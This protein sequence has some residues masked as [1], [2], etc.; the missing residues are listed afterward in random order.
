MATVID[1]LIVTLG[2]D[3]AGFKKGQKEATD[4]QKRFV[5]EQEENAKK[6]AQQAKSMVEGY[7]QVRNELLGLFAAAVG[8][9]GFKDWI[10]NTV[11]G[12]AQLGYLSKNL[13]MS[14]R[15]LDAWG[16]A[17]G[18]VGGTAEGFQNSLQT[19]ASSIESFKLGEDSPAVA[20]LRSIGVNI[21]DSTGKMR[22]FK[23]MLLDVSDALQRYGAQ[24]QIR[25]GQMLGIDAP[26]LNLLRKGRQ[27]VEGLFDQMYRSSRVT[28]E[29]VKSAQDAQAAW[30][31][32]K[33]EMK[34]VSDTLF[35]ALAPAMIEGTKQLENFGKWINDH[36]EEISEFFTDLVKDI[37]SLA[38]SFD[39]FS[40]GSD[41]AATKIIAL[42][43]ALGGL[44]AVMTKPVA[45][46]KTA[47]SALRVLG[48]VTGSTVAGGLFALLHSSELNAGEDEEVAQLYGRKPAELS[49]SD[50]NTLKAARDAWLK[51]QGIGKPKTERYIDFFMKQGWTR[52]Q[53]IG[54]VSNLMQE[55]DLNPNAVGDNGKAFGLAQWHPDRQADFMK[56]AG[57]DIRAASE[58]EQLA[59]IQHELTKGSRKGAGDRL[60]AATASTQAAGIVSQYY[61]SPAARDEEILKR[62]QLAQVLDRSLTMPPV[63]AT[64]NSEIASRPNVT[65]S[66]EVNIGQINIQTQ[67]TDATGIANGMQDAIAQNSLINTSITGQH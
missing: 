12:Q 51:M 47:L 22:P 38:D 62:G 1:A 2:L 49:K 66:N 28:E 67:A 50:S 34:G 41:V 26:T 4:S 53:A 36:H 61:E 31:N 35:V 33:G 19:L 39:K 44:I 42:T 58:Q 27:D 16:K 48:T 45:T 15:E 46:T 43:A 21:A 9:R 52:A 57:K 8:A 20:V 54:I 6:I 32:F 30:A 17:V 10:S 63:G 29:S 18:T 60:R 11:Q 5:R 40:G 56:W 64:A 14:A 13:S 3:T 25:V 55:S 7:R 59:F 37:G 65:N 23:D 24:D